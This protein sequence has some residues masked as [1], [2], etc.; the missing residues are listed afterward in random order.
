MRNRLRPSREEQKGITMIRKRDLL[1]YCDLIAEDVNDLYDE[2]HK[3]KVELAA[4]HE[5]K[6][7]NPIKRSKK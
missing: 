3:I 7:I 5:K 1:E 4:F 2:M 6:N